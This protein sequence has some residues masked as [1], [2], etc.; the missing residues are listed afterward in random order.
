MVCQSMVVIPELMRW[1]FEAP[2]PVSLDYVVSLAYA[3]SLACA[4][5]LAYAASSRPGRDP[6]LN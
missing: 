5:S 1:V 6:V 4:V 3:V 2:W